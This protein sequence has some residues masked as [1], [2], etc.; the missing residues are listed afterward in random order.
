MKPNQT[1]AMRTAW[2]SL[3][4]LCLAALF[5]QLDRQLPSVIVAPLKAEFGVSDTKFSLLHGFAFA[6]TYAIF[7][8]PFGRLVDRGNRRLII[9]VGLV[10]WSSL[11]AAAAF[12]TS[13]NQLILLRTGV[14]IGE[15]VLS[16]AAYSLIVD[17]FRPEQRGRAF[18]IYYIALALGGGGSL[19]FGGLI[20]A[21]VPPEGWVL[22]NIPL[23][24]WRLLFLF[25]GL[26]GLVI[27]L[28]VLTLR[29]P[30]RG[31]KSGVE[32]TSLAEFFK[33]IWRQRALLGRISVASVMVTTA[34]FG[35]V[36]WAPALFER[37]FGM[38]PSVAAVPLG[39]AT[40][41]GSIFGSMLGGWL[42]DRLVAR[43]ENGARARVMLIGYL[44][45]LPAAFWS[46]APSPWLAMLGVGAVVFSVGIVQSAMPLALQEAVPASMR[47]Q[48]IAL[49]LMI[50]GLLSFGLGPT[51]VALFT[52]QV[53]QND[54]MLPW[55]MVCV[56]LPIAVAGSL[57]CGFGLSA[58][59]HRRISDAATDAA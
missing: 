57:L 33:N 15:A 35:A 47:G 6:L 24:P 17:Y 21:A 2:Y 1:S 54:A 7:G 37:R 8:L 14:G 41:A 45:L 38:P 46:V 22:A 26:P 52:D 5:S 23:S 40:I 27:A 3:G 48:I 11:T 30:R 51:L 49:Q 55:S 34:G 13:F 36:A 9:F 4:V 43:G 10:A 31:G 28:L 18:S 39:M 59:A 19:I 16:P 58:A 12:A 25:A 32:H 56:A 44:A 20:F 50:V 29:E 53:F 42:S